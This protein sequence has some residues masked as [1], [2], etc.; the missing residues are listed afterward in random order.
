MFKEKQRQAKNEHS[1]SNY[2]PYASLVE[3][4]TV[5]LRDRTLLACFYIEGVT[6]ETKSNEEV[7]QA[8]SVINRFLTG[9]E[10]D[11]LSIQIH[12]IRRPFQDRL[13][14]SDCG[15]WF[16]DKFTRDYNRFTDGHAMMATELYISVLLGEEKEEKGFFGRI[17]SS[18]S[19]QK[20]ETLLKERLA[21]FR[22]YCDQLAMNF[23]DYNIVRLGSYEDRDEDGK[24]IVCSSQL[25]FLNFLITGYW[26]KVQIPAGPLYEGIGATQVFIGR[27]ILQL[28]S[29]F[30]SRYVQSIELKGLP[31][32]A[33]SGLLDSLL[34]PG[35][36][37]K[38]PYPFVESQFFKIILRKRALKVIEDQIRKLRTAN[39]KS[40]SQRVELVLAQDYIQ[41]GAFCL[42]DYAYSILVYG[43]TEEECRSNAQDVCTKL[44]TSG[45]TPY[46]SN[47]SAAPAYLSTMPGNFQWSPRPVKITSQNYSDFAPFHNFLPGKRDN[48]PWGQAIALVV[49]ASLQPYYINLHATNRF[50]NSYGEPDAGSTVIFGQT[51]AGKTALLSF[52]ATNAMK[53]ADKDH[54]FSMVF[55]DINHGAEILVNAFEGNYLSVENGKPTGF[56]PFQ[57][58]PTPDNL[59]F[60]NEFMRLLLR[61]N[62]APIS[63]LDE[64]K[65]EEAINSVMSMDKPLRRLSTLMQNITEGNSVEERENSIPRRLAKWYGRGGYAW[66]FDNVED[67]IDL[68]SKRVIGIDGTD[69]LDNSITK[70]PVAFYLLHRVKQIID[71]RRGMIF[72]DEFWAWLNDEAFRRFAEQE[73]KTIRKKNAIMVFATQSPS[74]VLNNPIARTVVE[75]TSTQIMLPNEK[76]DEEEYVKFFKA[77]PE[78]YNIVVNLPVKSRFFLVK[79]LNS[80]SLVR[81]D[82]SNF[83]DEMTVF[84]STTVNIEIMHE[85]REELKRNGVEDKPENWLP[86]FYEAV[87]ANKQ[88]K[89]RTLSTKR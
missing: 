52:L 31:A 30:G 61:G 79:Q 36:S 37:E 20:E 83:S 35:K 22:H 41:S 26:S 39:D 28:S 89:K 65:L 29:F 75:Q 50:A 59:T 5:M 12:R 33:S 62:G 2:I 63:T 88:Q 85:V 46:I 25:T 55:F 82:L 84:S 64:A 78:E 58:D 40:E 43:D 23:A 16:A 57:L 80:S 68:E 51:G 53:Y 42:G 74:D 21:Q 70:T 87:R 81:L 49:Q 15:N 17:T 38:K 9:L 66:V 4:D 1:L 10:D 67:K 6:F 60:L 14:P 69:F 54:K 19:Q 86:V 72:M 71:G 48:N 56:N 77:T 11:R 45:F 8:S 34:Y 18:V 24:R 47:L 13:D 44:T 32:A 73:L 7:E 27:D 3:D 76:A